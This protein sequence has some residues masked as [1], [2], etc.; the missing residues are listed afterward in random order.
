M[1]LFDYTATTAGELVREL[2]DSFRAKESE[3]NAEAATKA[4]INLLTYD[5]EAAEQF[6]PG[7][8]ELL[9]RVRRRLVN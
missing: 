7:L 9:D 3:A 2:V 1:E 8:C 6:G 4:L 5:K